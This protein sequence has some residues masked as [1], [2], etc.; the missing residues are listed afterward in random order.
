MSTPCF[1]RGQK[2]KRGLCSY[3]AHTDSAPADSPHSAMPFPIPGGAHFHGPVEASHLYRLRA[4]SE[5]Q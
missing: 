2:G 3:A 5:L 4:P 1:L